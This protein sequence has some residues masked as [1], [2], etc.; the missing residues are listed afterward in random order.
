MDL[1]TEITL[2][3]ALSAVTFFVGILLVLFFGPTLT[4]VGIVLITVGAVVFVVDLMD[5]IGH[6]RRISGE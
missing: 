3:T 1:N 2:L 4:T 5:A 6:W